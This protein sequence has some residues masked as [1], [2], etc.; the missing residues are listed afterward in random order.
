MVTELILPWSDV[1]AAKEERQIED[2]TLAT[3][4]YSVNGSC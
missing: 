1:F 3:S 4:S 2:N